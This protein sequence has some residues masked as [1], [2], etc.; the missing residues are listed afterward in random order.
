[1]TLM[2]RN[3]PISVVD[4]TGNV[5]NKYANVTI[6]TEFC[7]AYRDANTEAGDDDATPTDRSANLPAVTRPENN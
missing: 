3:G 5:K 7:A 1:M 2:L 6:D 4:V